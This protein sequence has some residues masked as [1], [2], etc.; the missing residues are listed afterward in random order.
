WPSSLC[1]LKAADTTARHS[2]DTEAARKEK[3]LFPHSH[4]N[5]S[6][7]GIDRASSC[8]Q[9]SLTSECG[10]ARVAPVRFEKIQ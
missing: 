6:G 4:E 9:R 8:E 10:P 2:K 3:R 7:E 5:P 1:D